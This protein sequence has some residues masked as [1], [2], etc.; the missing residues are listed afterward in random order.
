METVASDDEGSSEG[1][2]SSEVA[3]LLELQS[4]G[5]ALRHE[6]RRSLQGGR[7]AAAAMEVTSG[8][9][10]AIAM[11]AL[12]DAVEVRL[13]APIAKTD[14]S[15]CNSLLPRPMPWRSRAMGT[16]MSRVASARSVNA[17]RS[18]WHGDDTILDLVA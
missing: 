8:D 14:V 16:G 2:G 6:G 4:S 12:V 7:G 15:V 10:L 9:S 1:E 11:Q 3:T 17:L 5:R 18:S 13:P